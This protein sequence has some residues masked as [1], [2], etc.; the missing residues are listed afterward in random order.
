MKMDVE[1]RKA[2]KNRTPAGLNKGQTFVEFAIAIPGLLLIA[3]G[4]AN[5][6]LAISA[7]SFVC[8]GARDG[9]R[10]AAVRGAASPKP[11]SADDVRNFVKSEASGLDLSQLTVATTWSPDNKQESRVAVQVQYTFQFLVPFVQLPQVNLRSTSQM[12]ISQ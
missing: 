5:F 10:F 4:I 1:F 2:R 6:A 12:V 8:Y 3:I 11:A 9:T 7:Y